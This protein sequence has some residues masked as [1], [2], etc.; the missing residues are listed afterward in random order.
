[1]SCVARKWAKIGSTTT[2][3]P[4]NTAL[5]KEMNDRLKEIQEARNTMDAAWTEK[6][7][8]SVTALVVTKKKEQVAVPI[9]DRAKTRGF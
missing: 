1:M 9:F 2:E 6:K 3:R 5:A 7:E 4:S 8:E